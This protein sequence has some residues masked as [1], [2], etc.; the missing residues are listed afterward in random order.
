MVTSHWPPASSGQL[1]YCGDKLTI[2]D[3]AH[4]ERFFIKRMSK[5]NKVFV[6]R[7]ASLNLTISKVV[8]CPPKRWARPFILSIIQ[9][10]AHDCSCSHCR[11]AFVHGFC[12]LRNI[13]RWWLKSCRKL[14]CK[15]RIVRETLNGGKKAE[16]HNPI[17]ARYA[18]DRL[19]RIYG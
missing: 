3:F 12:I 11:T 7:C 13:V 6:T 9:R 2:A 18:L 5:L 4:D 19:R 15:V 8:T 14:H 17:F 10:Y 16:D 1:I